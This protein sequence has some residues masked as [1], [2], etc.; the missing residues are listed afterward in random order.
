MAIVANDGSWAVFTPTKCGTTSLEGLLCDILKVGVKSKPRHSMF[1]EDHSVP[2]SAMKYMIVRDPRDRWASMY[3]A[4]DRWTNNGSHPF[5]WEYA[6]ELI[7]F[8]EEWLTRR[9]V[10]PWDDRRK[11]YTIY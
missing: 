5:L 4:I 10:R 8:V 7:P 3:W 1:I 6:G 9:S 11:D 2:L